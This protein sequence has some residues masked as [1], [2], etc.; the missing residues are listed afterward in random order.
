MNSK[1]GKRLE[2]WCIIA[3]A[4]ISTLLYTYF[5][6]GQFLRLVY[7]QAKAFFPDIVP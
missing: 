1:T 3:A 5:Q 7:R 2:A 4:V 6:G